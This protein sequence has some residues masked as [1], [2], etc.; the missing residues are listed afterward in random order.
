M[1]VVFLFVCSTMLLLDT[2]IGYGQ[3]FND[4]G[5][6]LTGA[7]RSAVAWGDYDSDD[8]LDL[9]IGGDGSGG[10]ATKLYRNDDS[11][12][13][14]ISTSIPGVVDGSLAWGDYDK[15]NDLDI[16]LTSWPGTTKVYRNDGGG[17]FVEAATLTGVWDGA[18]EWMD[19]DGDGDLDIIIVGY[20]PSVSTPRL[21]FYR[22]DNGSFT[23]LHIENGYDK[24]FIAD[25][26][27]DND[28]DLDFLITGRDA[29]LASKT[30]VFRNDGSFS[31]TKLDLGFIA[32]SGGSAS[33]GDYESDGD[34]DL[35]LTGDDGFSVY[36]R[37]YRND[38][39]MFTDIAATLPGITRGNAAWGDCDNDG[40]LDI[41]IS[42]FA[43][44]PL[45]RVYRND[46]GSTFTDVSAGLH[47]VNDGMCAW[48]DYNH[49]GKLDLVV[50][51]YDA[52]GP[53]HVTKI[54]RNATVTSNTLPSIPSNLVT[55]TNF[56]FNKVVLRWNRST[57]AQ[58]PSAALTYNIRI[59]DDP[60]EVNVISPTANPVSGFLKIV[61]SGNRGVD[62]SFTIDSLP[63]GNYLWSVQAIDHASAGSAFA[64][65]QSFFL[66]DTFSRFRPADALISVF[67]T[68]FDWGDF[69]GDND[70]DL[71]VTGDS[72]SQKIIRVYRQFPPGNFSITGWGASGR[73]ARW[74]DYDN[75]GDL[76]IATIGD[77]I[78]IHRND[79]NEVFTRLSVNDPGNGDAL[80]WGDYDNDGDLDFV[81]TGFGGNRIYQNNNGTF[82]GF[83]FVNA[84]TAFTSVEWGD[85]DGDSDLDLLV[86]SV[87]VEPND[88]TVAIYRNEGGGTFTDIKVGFPQMNYFADAS[89][90]DYDNDGDLDVAVVGD[91][92]RLYRNE[93][94][95]TFIGMDIG[96]PSFLDKCTA[97]WGDYDNDGDLDLIAKAAQT[98]F[99]ATSGPILYRNEGGGIFTPT[100]SGVLEC[101]AEGWAA[102]WGDY[103]G[104]RNLDFVA[105]CKVLEGITT[106]ARILSNNMIIA[107][108]NAQPSPPT[109]LTAA[110]G[111]SATSNIRLRWVRATDTETAQPG[112]SY[113]LRI[114][115]SMGGVN[116][117]SPMA[118]LTNG[119]RRIAYLGNVSQDTSW[120]LDSLPTRGYWSVQSIDH[121]YIGSNWATEQAYLLNNVHDG[122]N[123]IS[124]PHTVTNET[125]SALF[126]TASSDA[127]SYQG[128]Y[129]VSPTLANGRGYWLKFNGSQLIVLGGVP[130]TGEKINIKTGWN[131][132]GSIS[133]PVEVSTI[134]SVPSGIVTSPFY[135]YNSTYFMADTI[136]PGYGYWMKSS[137]DGQLVLSGSGNT[138]RAGRISIV[139]TS[140]MPP[141]P[142]TDGQSPTEESEHMP[143]KFALGQNFPNP[144][145]PTTEITYQLPAK[146]VVRLRVYNLLGEL[147]TT[148][149][150]ESQEAGDKMVRWDA[151][152]SQSGVYFYVLRAM[153]LDN[154]YPSYSEVRKMM[155]LR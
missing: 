121:S 5:A 103:N 4:I 72:S 2:E 62:T 15:D 88:T 149:V 60:S 27:Y 109:G 82:N 52:G 110:V 128:S 155:L 112:L 9:I 123:L 81:V 86:A 94:G 132:I 22:N 138:T 143:R 12:F 19:A 50:T 85:Y 41:L 74:G 140:E 97:A 23:F 117:L 42:G 29:L 36:S 126:P 44:G 145:N 125:K 104:D 47:N 154:Q 139:S 49:D 76:D 146:S 61:Q 152:G 21:V 17:A 39:A 113:N 124:V 77:S 45:S 122:W 1:K 56:G 58:T 80:A 131:I 106:E 57:D 28:G 148:L 13:T 40:D 18:G 84:L 25:G 134:T 46:S 7:S 54:Y 144:F 98:N 71:L 133:E 83:N 102:A 64:T 130:R 129:E 48:A 135:G 96:L 69:D 65:T 92:G 73:V 67:P 136:E 89:W 151:A 59:G 142:P 111:D 66:A 37:I 137:Q 34:L 14:P 87:A 115:T 93:G 116:T 70:L 51:G 68:S 20:E 147:V 150:D 10:I 118:S 107:K 16:L 141:P 91:S 55:E 153:P 24:S 105:A 3:P 11:S 75:D 95:G 114:G 35:L 79:G 33:W 127:F 63:F 78:A 8:D 108:T 99:M 6:G 26:D 53:V 119:Y 120:K 30:I 101:N 32:V 43:P 100:H 90:G 31:F 38:S